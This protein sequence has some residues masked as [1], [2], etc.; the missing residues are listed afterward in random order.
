MSTPNVSYGG[1]VA[2]AKPAHFHGL[3]PEE[4][5]ARIEALKKRYPEGS[6][7]D[8]RQNI[9]I[10]VFP[11]ASYLPLKALKE[12]NY[13]LSR[14]VDHFKSKLYRQKEATNGAVQWGLAGGG[15]GAIAGA[16]LGFAVGGP[17]ALGAVGALLV[18]GIAAFLGNKFGEA[19]ATIKDTEDDD[20][21]VLNGSPSPERYDPPQFDP[22]YF[23]DR[24]FG[25]YGGYAGYG[26]YGRYGGGY[27]M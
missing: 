3:R 27:M 26:G 1:G 2:G 17:L 9:R 7:I 13:A 5:E 12:K 24:N 8:H 25:G 11:P 22:A 6:H 4:L 18:G 21:R 14:E 20:Q 15:L 23:R 16:A 10:P 19:D